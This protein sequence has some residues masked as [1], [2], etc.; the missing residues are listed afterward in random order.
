MVR[1]R[2]LGLLLRGTVG[3]P[4]GCHPPRP[5][6]ALDRAR[7]IGKRG[8]PAACDW[9]IPASR[10][11]LEIQPA[12]QDPR[13]GL[14]QR[15]EI[16]AARFL[17]RPQLG[18]QRCQVAGKARLAARGEQPLHLQ[19]VPRQ[20]DIERIRMAP[21]L[22]RAFCRHAQARWHPGTIA[23]QRLE[24]QAPVLLADRIGDARQAFGFEA[25]EEVGGQGGGYPD[26][27]GGRRRLR[28]CAPACQPLYAARRRPRQASP[29]TAYH[30]QL[31]SPIGI[32]AANRVWS[33]TNSVLST[34]GSAST[35][36][37][38]TPMTTAGPA[39]VMSNR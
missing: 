16:D 3:G 37:T 5:G 28:P 29:N 24:L 26:I 17:P 18:R 7:A 9:L 22:R 12:D 13:I 14:R 21:Q 38:S 15:A 1:D 31:C 11:V 20:R 10:S 4:A 2:D 23:R 30:W 25:G 39:A 33:P 34:S 32:S 8:V 19:P 35:T 6:I 27:A 36:A